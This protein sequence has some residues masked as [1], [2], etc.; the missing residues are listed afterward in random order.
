MR[1]KI[2]NQETLIEESRNS[3]EGLQALGDAIMRYANDHIEE[4]FKLYDLKEMGYARLVIFL[5]GRVL[6]FE[7][8][9]CTRDAPSLFNPA[10]FEWHWSKQK[11]TVKK[12]QLPALHTYYKPTNTKW[13]AWHGLG[14]NQ[15][16]FTGE[17]TWWPQE[18]DP[19][20]ITFR[21]PTPEEKIDVE[22]FIDL[23]DRLSDRS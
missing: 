6:Y 15:L 7:R 21:L 11:N 23:L 9:L 5:T 18:G 2:P 13:W 10:D 3:A 19:H 17:T 1:A 12:E 22:T 16:H 20:A 14:E 4:S 8:F